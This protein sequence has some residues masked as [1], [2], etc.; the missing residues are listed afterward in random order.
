MSH[1]FKEISFIS[2]MHTLGVLMPIVDTL[3]NAVDNFLK[4]FTNV[5]DQRCFDQSLRH[6]VIKT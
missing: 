1:K 2:A 3:S 6:R 4:M 5:E